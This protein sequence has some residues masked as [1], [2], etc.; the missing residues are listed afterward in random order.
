M[1][2]TSAKTYEIFTIE[3][4]AQ[5][6][7]RVRATHGKEP[8]TGI[9]WDSNVWNVK[10]MVGDSNLN[11]NNINLLFHCVNTAYSPK[12]LVPW[13]EDFSKVCM[14]HY[15][16]EHR[17]SYAVANGYLLSL[18]WLNEIVRDHAVSALNELLP[19]HFTK[20]K[21]LLDATTYTND[22]K[23]RICASLVTIVKLICKFKLTDQKLKYV[24]PYKLSH[25]HSKKIDKT[26]AP[27]A[28][29]A[30]YHCFNNPADDDERIIMEMLRVHVATGNRIGE[31]HLLLHDSFFKGEGG[32]LV[33]VD[34]FGM[35][36][37][38]DRG[39]GI[40]YLREKADG[41]IYT[42]PLDRATF[43]IVKHSIAQLDQ[44]CAPA[45]ARATILANMPNR[46]PLPVNLGSTEYHQLSDFVTRRYVED[47]IGFKDVSKWCQAHDIP[48]YTLREACQTGW[49]GTKTVN[50]QVAFYQ[51]ADVERACLRYVDLVVLR[52]SNGTP[53]LWLHDILAVIVR[54]QLNFGGKGRLGPLFPIS[55]PRGMLQT[56]LT[57]N[58]MRTT[59]FERRAM[60]LPDGS[61]IKIRTHQT[62]HNRNRFLDEAGL[63]QIHQAQ[64]MGREPAQNEAYQGGSDI[65]IIQQS[66]LA[67]LALED[68]AKR[69]SITK[70][71]VRAGL[72]QG[73]IPDTYR[74]LRELCVVK[75]EEFLE[76]QIGQVLITRFGVCTNEWSGQACAKH[77]KCFKRCSQYH[78]TGVSSERVELEKE[79][80]I[81]QLHR[82]K[83]EEMAE[84]KVYRADV[85]LRNLDSEIVSIKDALIQW[86]VASSRRA[87]VELNTSKLAAIAISVQV[88]PEG[89]SHYAEVRRPRAST[90]SEGT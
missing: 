25:P 83:V 87:D 58:P 73:R 12:P 29:A 64:A 26:V 32:S 48:T 39:F 22:T 27:E 7:A 19:H 42:K 17:K 50:S 23:Q 53:K 85:A 49:T 28:M 36:N 71:A 31:T 5:L 56:Q 46:F 72:I 54:N 2:S 16:G 8:K 30:L 21:K 90:L 52:D 77:N 41:G 61:P 79:L 75:A 44:L 89:R 59:M 65:N 69:I 88:Y 15:L 14:A 55:V 4:K 80:A 6:A 20:V 24:N 35:K 62:R 78:V 13:L 37:E 1:N 11:G 84:E 9:D 66:H 40:R 43:E 3:A 68:Q 76:E 33:Q 34:P 18:R 60:T 82:A 51:V 70:N 57:P 67:R 86:G 47:V 10:D 45:R 38:T 74:S 81:Q 63:S